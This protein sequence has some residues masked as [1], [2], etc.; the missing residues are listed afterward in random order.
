ML[1]DIVPCTSKV[2]NLTFQSQFL[3]SKINPY[4]LKMVFYLIYWLN[5]LGQVELCIFGIKYRNF[6]RDSCIN[7][8][9]TWVLIFIKLTFSVMTSKLEKFLLS[10]L[11]QSNLVLFYKLSK[12]MSVYF[13]LHRSIFKQEL[14]SLHTSA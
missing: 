14:R 1:I 12:C 2:Q 3:P 13:E 5:K 8:S 7:V 4:C 9:G 11:R 6:G 10:H